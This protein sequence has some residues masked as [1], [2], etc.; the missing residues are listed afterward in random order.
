[1]CGV[2]QLTVQLDQL[3]LGNIVYVK[4]LDHVLLKNM[5]EGR[6]PPIVVE[7]VGWL[8]EVGK[9]YI[10]VEFERFKELKGLNITQKMSSITIIKSAILE[11]RV[12]SRGK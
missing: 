7:L 11:L 4:Y 2:R 1:M 9:D 10:R 8:A 6:Y 12:L 3:E 5:E